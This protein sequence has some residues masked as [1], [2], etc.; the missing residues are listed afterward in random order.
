MEVSMSWAGEFSISAA[1]EDLGSHSQ[2]LAT[3]I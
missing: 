3:S 1:V 2:W